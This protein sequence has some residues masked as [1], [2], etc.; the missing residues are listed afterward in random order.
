MSTGSSVMSRMIIEGAEDG[1]EGGASYGHY[2]ETGF[3]GGPDRDVAWE[4]LVTLER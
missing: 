1:T 4:G 3:D 2:T